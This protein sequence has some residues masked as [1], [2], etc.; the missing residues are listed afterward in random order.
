M[1]RRPPLSF[2]GPLA[3]AAVAAAT[4]HLVTLPTPAPLVIAKQDCSEQWQRSDSQDIWDGNAT[5]ALTGTVWF[6]RRFCRAGKLALNLHGEAAGGAPA[7]LSIIADGSTLPD[8]PVEG[9]KALSLDVK[10]GQLLQIG[11]FNPYLRRESRTTILMGFELSGNS[12]KSLQV[13]YPSE[14]GGQWFPDQ[15]SASLVFDVPMTVTPCASGLLKF[16]TTGQK[17][18]GE[19]ARLELTQNGGKTVQEIQVGRELRKHT[20]ELTGGPLHIK[21][22]NPYLNVSEIRRLTLQA[23]QFTPAPSK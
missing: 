11:F 23:A 7:V 10:K 22:K 4:P 13:D 15:N 21:I 20:V 3:A 1:T 9:Q 5:A 17:A 18:R 14:A 8:T 6:E 19:Y 12:C 2:L 16:V